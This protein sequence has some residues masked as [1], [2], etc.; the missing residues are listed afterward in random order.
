MFGSAGMSIIGRNLFFVVSQTRWGHTPVPTTLLHLRK[1]LLI[2]LFPYLCRLQ[3]ER[4]EVDVEYSVSNSSESPNFS[5]IQHHHRN[6]VT[7]QRVSTLSASD[8]GIPVV[9][10]DIGVVSHADFTRP[11]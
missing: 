2:V 8:D 3:V 4:R 7:G 11:G 1:P 9:A 10:G 6:C 5:P